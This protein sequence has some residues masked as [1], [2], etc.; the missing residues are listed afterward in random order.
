M[1][2]CKDR[3]CYIHGAKEAKC[4]WGDVVQCSRCRRYYAPDG[5]E[6]MPRDLPKYNPGHEED[7]IGGMTDDEWRDVIYG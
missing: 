4:G 5:A 3:D 1:S 7:L 2:L 6:V